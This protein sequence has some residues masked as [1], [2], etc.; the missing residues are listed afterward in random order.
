MGDDYPDSVV[1]SVFAIAELY[2]I[3]LIWFVS[4]KMKYNEKRE[5]LHGKSY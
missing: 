3:D 1:Y 5:L 2:E 4:E